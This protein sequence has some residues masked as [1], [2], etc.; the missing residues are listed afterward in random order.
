M[1]ND[2]QTKAGSRL[3]QKRTREG[4]DPGCGVLGWGVTKRTPLG[5]EPRTWIF[6]D[7]AL[8]FELWGVLQ[9]LLWWITYHT[10]EIVSI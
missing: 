4:S 1:K 7:P 3:G 5:V 9:T 2:K 10:Y 6:G 8:S